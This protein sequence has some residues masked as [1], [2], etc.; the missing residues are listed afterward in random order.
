ME[1]VVYNVLAMIL[2]ISLTSCRD[3]ETELAP[4]ST[5]EVVEEVPEET[6]ESPIDGL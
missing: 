3:L 6:W 2:L 5:Q 1:K 4:V